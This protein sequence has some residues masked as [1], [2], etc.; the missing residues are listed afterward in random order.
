MT[1]VYLAIVFLL[2]APVEVFARVE[3][4][5]LVGLPGYTPGTGGF[6]NFV[7]YVYGL[8]ISV[9]ALL[10]VIKIVL[11]GVK[12]MLSDVVTD[13]TDAKKD[14]EG[15]LIGLIVI[16]SAVLIISTINPTIVGGTP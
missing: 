14:I 5:P 12:W 9:A 11:A 1:Y 10:A 15:A 6:T 7:N 4:T 13:K 3:Y 8:S 2:S 16:I